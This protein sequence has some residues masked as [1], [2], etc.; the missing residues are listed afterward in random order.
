ML[1]GKVIVVTGGGGLLGRHFC[2]GIAANGGVVVVADRDEGA[3]RRVAD[4]IVR[5]YPGGALAA[6]FDMTDK[7]SVCSLISLVMQQYGR[8]DGVVNNAYPRNKSY[9]QKFETVT[10]ADFCE[11]VG[12]HLGGYF[13]V[14]QQFGLFFREQGYGNIVNMSSIYGVVAPKFEIYEGTTMTM[15]VEYA[16]IKA[17]VNH[18][19][20][21]MARYFR[22]DGIRVN[23]LSPGGIL[24]TQPDSFVDAYRSHCSGTGMLAP[25]DLVSTLLFL[26]SDGSRHING[27]N[28]IVDDGF[29]L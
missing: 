11:N 2:E 6:K 13:L 23:C 17:G 1:N 7:H 24:D 16:A 15:P 22:S 18:L 26:L 8:I 3:A 12:L 27:Q 5:S 25:N 4:T 21:Y 14:A 10:Y 29:T 9:G 19:T 20:R 28:L